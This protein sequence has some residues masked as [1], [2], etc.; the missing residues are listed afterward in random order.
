MQSWQVFV[1]YVYFLLVELA[2]FSLTKLDKG[3]FLFKKKVV[4]NSESGQRNS[5][6]TY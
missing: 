6:V 2:S 3:I 5:S 1:R 4:L